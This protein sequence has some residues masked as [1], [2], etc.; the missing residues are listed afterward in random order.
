MIE[1]DYTKE[2][3]AIEGL[4]GTGK[5]ELTKA[6]SKLYDYKQVYEPDGSTPITKKFR[7][8]A[9]KEEFSDKVKGK[10]REYIHAAN[11]AITNE[12]T[13]ELL[14]K[15][16]VI[17]D[18]SIVSGRVYATMENMNMETWENIQKENI[19]TLMPRIV[20]YV[21]NK[22]RKT[23]EEKLN[24]DDIYDHKDEEFFVELQKVYLESLTY[25]RNKWG[26]V[27]IKFENDFNYTPEQNAV[28]L[29]ELLDNR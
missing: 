20:V 25:F 2:Y 5:S 15:H 13:K 4:D 1:S 24:N 6:F 29:K 22:T 12:T 23:P 11:R 21:T 17:S 28:R 27:S 8:F 14:K 18:R 26:L 19:L 3:I 7:E 10:P 16:N 9:L